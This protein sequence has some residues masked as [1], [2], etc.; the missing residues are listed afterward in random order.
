[1]HAVILTLVVVVARGDVAQG[2]L[3]LHL[4]EVL[5]V[6]DVEQRLRRVRD[7]PDHDGRDL[8]R[9]AALVV[10][11]EGID[12]VVACPHADGLAA[13]PRPGPAQPRRALGADVVAEQGEH[14]ALVRLEH[15][16]AAGD[17]HDRDADRHGEGGRASAHEEKDHAPDE[18]EQDQQH[19]NPVEG[20]GGLLVG[21]FAA[22]LDHGGGPGLV[23]AI[24]E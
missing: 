22:Q 12:V 13:D 18:G 16:E 17:E 15:E 6:V 20:G 14:A 24:L 4:H 19:E 8:H 2:G 10:D 11:L 21:G 3:A 9:V 7:A 23:E 5:E 1:V